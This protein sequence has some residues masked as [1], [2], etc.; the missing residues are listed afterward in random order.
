VTD[1]A[2]WTDG[3]A[4]ELLRSLFDAA[5][6]SA[7]PAQVLAAH[8]PEP[9]TGRCV[10]VGAGKAAAAMALAVEATWQDVPLTGVVVAPYGY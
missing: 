2:Q 10:V 4:R 5:V 3:A 6:A 8:L 9:P 7:D 1:L